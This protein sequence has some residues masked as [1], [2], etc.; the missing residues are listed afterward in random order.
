MGK[1]NTIKR[2]QQPSPSAGPSAVG[3]KG[4]TDKES[5]GVHTIYPLYI[6]ERPEPRKK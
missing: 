6:E 3:G 2:L 1:E 4:T 5:P